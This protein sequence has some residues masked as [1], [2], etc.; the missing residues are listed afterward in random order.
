MPQEGGFFQDPKFY[1]FLGS[2]VGAIFGS[3]GAIVTTVYAARSRRSAE[4]EQELERV[5]LKYL[6]PLRVAAVDLRSRLEDLSE[7]VRPGSGEDNRWVRDF[8]RIDSG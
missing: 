8:R 5:R 2:V 7:K 3:A 6:N 1:A 4:R